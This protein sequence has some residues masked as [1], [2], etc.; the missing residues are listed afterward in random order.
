MI[1]SFYLFNLVVLFLLFQLK[2]KTAFSLAIINL[3]VLVL[4]LFLHE[5]ASLMIRL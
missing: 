4:F 1:S 5:G 3:I 2:K